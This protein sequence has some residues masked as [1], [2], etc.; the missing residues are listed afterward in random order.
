VEVQAFLALTT[1]I[2][3]AKREI[4]ETDRESSCNRHLAL[5][6]EIKNKS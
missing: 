2:P 3:T 4:A 1:V 5:A 6:K